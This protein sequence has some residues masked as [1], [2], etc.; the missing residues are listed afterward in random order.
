MIKL[1]IRK[2]SLQV[3]NVG[4]N[5]TPQYDVI[6]YDSIGYGTTQQNTEHATNEIFYYSICSMV[7]LKNGKEQSP[8][9]TSKRRMLLPSIC[10][11]FGLKMN[12][13]FM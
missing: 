6:Q 8:L 10:D 7:C 11:L 2:S 5:N 4:P 9:S 1:Q 12:V 13:F 3:P